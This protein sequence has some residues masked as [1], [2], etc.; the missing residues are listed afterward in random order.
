[1]RR[2]ADPRLWL[3]SIP[4]AWQAVRENATEITACYDNLRAID[5]VT[6]ASRHDQI[7]IA[8]STGG[9]VQ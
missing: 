9:S 2:P 3:R 8:E 5:V 4:V 6:K 7:P 1:L